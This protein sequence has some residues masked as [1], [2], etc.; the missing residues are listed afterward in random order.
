MVVLVQVHAK[1]KATDK[2]LEV[3]DANVC[4]GS[5]QVVCDGQVCRDVEISDGHVCA[6]TCWA[7]CCTGVP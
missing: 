3:S 7:I 2:F 6:G 4:T 1:Q 5:F